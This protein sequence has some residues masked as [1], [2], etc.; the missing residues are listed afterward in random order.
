MSDRRF[1]VIFL[2]DVV[3]GQSLPEVKSRLAKLF[4]APPAKVEQ[5]F[6][7]RPVVIKRDLD[8]EAAEHYRNALKE[9]GAL[10]DIRPVETVS[11]IANHTGATEEKG[12]APT[13]PTTDDSP[14]QQTLASPSGPENL[15]AAETIDVAP[16]GADVLLSE[17]R[18]DFTPRD[19]DTS[20]MTVDEPGVDVL[21]DN[22]KAPFVKRDVDTSHLSVK[23]PDSEGF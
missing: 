16:V 21:K 14:A 2:G 19:L 13:G 20:Y 5:M 9:A 7:G 11:E 8:E 15:Q 17:Y 18:R 6:S 4:G 3:P 12:Q 23:E 1:E 22:E 10:V